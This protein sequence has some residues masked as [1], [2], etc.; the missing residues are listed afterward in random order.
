MAEKEY[1]SVAIVCKSKAEA[2]VFEKIINTKYSLHSKI[3]IKVLPLYLAKGLEYDC[4]AVWDISR[5]C[6]YT[7]CTRAMHELLIINKGE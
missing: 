1:E 3:N 2:D 7:A 6:M 4:V 5:D